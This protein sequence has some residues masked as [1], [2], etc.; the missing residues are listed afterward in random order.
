LDVD[1]EDLKRARAKAEKLGL[2]RKVT[3]LNMFIIRE[4]EDGKQFNKRR[5]KRNITKRADGGRTQKVVR[6]DK[7]SIDQFKNQRASALL[8][9]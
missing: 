1:Q 7:K 8:E 9:S 3:A 4:D 2:V 6:P 5:A